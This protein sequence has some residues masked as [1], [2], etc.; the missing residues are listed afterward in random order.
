MIQPYDHNHLYSPRP[1]FLKMKTLGI[2]D[3]HRKFFFMRL[4]LSKDTTIREVKKQ[5]QNIFKSLKLEFFTMRHVAGESSALMDRLSDHTRLS[6]ASK[7]FREGEFLFKGSDTVAAFEKQLQDEF[8]LSVQVFR[9]SGS[10]WIET[11]QTDNLSL[12]KQNTLDAP[13]APARFNL[14]TLFL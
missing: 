6:A 13:P 4:Q 5:F 7:T 11:V 1:S 14:N 10:I 8:G 3:H 9:K 12:E 2:F